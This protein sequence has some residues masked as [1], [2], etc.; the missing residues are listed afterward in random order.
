MDDLAPI[1]GAFIPKLDAIAAR[2]ADVL[3]L[4]DI[5]PSDPQ[6]AG[7][8]PSRIRMVDCGNFLNRCG[9][10]PEDVLVLVLDRAMRSP[11]KG[12]PESMKTSRRLVFTAS[13]SCRMKHRVT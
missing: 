6:W 9:V 11:C 12:A 8:V 7:V 13:A 1:M 3:V 2:N 4:T 10:G 5:N